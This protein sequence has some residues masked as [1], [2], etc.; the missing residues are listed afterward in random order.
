MHIPALLQFLRELSEN[1]TK[2]WF[3]H[4]K[5]HYDILRAEFID[6]IAEVGKRIQKFDDGLGPFE[7]KKALFRIYR[8][9]RFSHDKSPLKTHLGAVI[10]ART[11][12]K[13]RPVYYIHIDHTGKLLVASGIWMPEKEAHKKIRDALA[14]D[15]KP[16]TKVLMNKVFVDTYGAPSDEG[17]MTRPPKGYP[18]DLPMI[19][20]IKNRHY[21][22]VAETNLHKKV[23]KDLAL[24]IAERCEAAYPL[25]KWLRDTTANPNLSTLL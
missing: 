8:D 1:N 3:L 23:P 12:D 17:R 14:K 25:V 6:L 16:F 11:T 4:N 2:S 7:A 19:E 13:T 9:V 24:W 10:G 5:P 21:I 15:A 18:A 22:C 20:Y